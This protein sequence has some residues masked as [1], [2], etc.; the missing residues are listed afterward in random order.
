M[1][2]HPS[3]L[4]QPSG[5]TVDGSLGNV[6]DIARS[7]AVEIDAPCGGRETCGKCRVI[8]R[9]GAEYLSPFK[10]AEGR[11]L[12]D[13]EIATGYRLSCCSSILKGGRV[14]LEVPPESQLGIQRLLAGGMEPDVTLSPVVTKAYLELPWPGAGDLRADT[15]RFLQVAGEKLGL[16]KVSIG[17][18]VLKE[19]PRVLRE[20]DW[21]LTCV[22]KGGEVIDIESGDTKERI[23]GFAVDV[24][25]TKI[26][27]YLVDLLT[28]KVLTSISTLNPQ[29]KHGGDVITRIAFASKA[30]QNLEELHKSVIDAVTNM[31]S[32]A[33]G[34][35][36]LKQS[37]IYDVVVVGNTAMHHFF[38]NIDPMSVGKSPYAAVVERPLNVRAKD[39]GLGVNKGAC[40]HSPPNIAGFVGADAVADIIATEIHRAEELTLLIDI[41][42]NVE[43]ILGDRTG[44][45]ACS[46]PAGPALEGAEISC[47]MR[48]VEGAIESVWID[49]KDM[50]VGYRTIGRDAR[51]KGICGSGA[52][53]AIAEMLKVRLISNSGEINRNGGM[54]RVRVQNG[55]R[56]FVIALKDDTSIGKDI[57]ITQEDVRQIQLAKAAVFTGVLMSM[58]HLGVKESDVKKVYVAGAFGTYLNPQ[59]ARNIGMYHDIPLEKIRFVGNA[60]GAGA[61]ALLKS[62]TLRDEA[63]DLARRIKYFPIGDEPDFQNDFMNALYIPHKDLELFPSV[64]RLLG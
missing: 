64:K 3:V 8:V 17:Y 36:D 35:L 52:V 10:D 55:K 42:T 57:V 16:N 29:M 44:L 48:A 23:Y 41:G 60:A 12:S 53:D 40:V 7:I 27:G 14:V 32:E 6:M 25:T 9:E 62:S 33:C 51:P 46:T 49:P 26:A 2:K 30:Q 21:K 24:G 34:K 28:G 56:E 13:S 15:D 37:E 20:G 19:L 1:T 63:R 61:R 18:D 4:F 31:I 45:Q 38:F 5:K 59:S 58:R 11:F 50:T 39:L 43:I 54:G 22:V 47:G